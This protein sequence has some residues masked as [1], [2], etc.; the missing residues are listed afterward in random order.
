[1]V[2][3][4]HDPERRRDFVEAGVLERKLL[5]VADD[6][7]DLEAEILGA[8]LG[9]LDQNGREIEPGHASSG[10]TG[11]LGDRARAG[12]EIEP[13]VALPGDSVS[14]TR[15]WMSPSVSVIRW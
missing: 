12:G 9:G 13:A 7:F 10:G 4:E 3:R 11:T 14:I 2:G 8:L 6:V 1:V 15:S 5:D